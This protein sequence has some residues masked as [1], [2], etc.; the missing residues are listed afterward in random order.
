MADIR[1]VSLINLNAYTV[2]LDGVDNET[3]ASQMYEH[4]GLIEPESPEYGWVSRGF[5]QYEDLVV[6]VTKAITHL[7]NSIKSVITQ[8]SNKECVI[9]DIW[10]VILTKDQSV[11]S[12]NHS[13]NLHPHPEEYFSFAYYPDAPEGSAELI[14]SVGYCNKM[15]HIMPVQPETGLLVIFNSYID[16]M[17]A[18]HKLD[19]PR[20]VIS[21]NTSPVNPN[22]E[23]NADWSVY[24][25]RPSLDID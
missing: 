20:L 25:A 7:E 22:L 4:A 1:Q 6:P 15:S 10:G 23:P 12:H 2:K 11:I 5:V 19:T 8:I 14:F 13:S 16:H 21:G 17:T 3:I 18:R 24:H 9:D